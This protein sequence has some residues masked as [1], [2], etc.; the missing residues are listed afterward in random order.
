MLHVKILN[1]EDIAGGAGGGLTDAELRATPVDVAIVSGSS[2]GTEY[3]EGDTDASISGGAILWEDTSDTLRAVSAA[4]PLPVNVVAGGT[5]GTQY[6]EADTDASIT[7]TAIMW[8]DTSDTLRAVSASKP[9]PVSV[10]AAIPAGTNNIGDVDVLTLPALAAGTNNIGDV[11][12]LTVPAPLSTTGNGTAAAALRVTVASDST[13]VLAVTDNGGTLSI[14]DGAGS[15][16]VDAT[17]LSCNVAQMNGTAVTMGN[18]ASGT[19]VQR[20]TLANDSTGVLATVSTVTTVSTL[21]GG[22]VAH[23]GGDSGNPIKIGLKAKSSLSG[24]TLVSADD[25]TDAFADL[26]GAQITK[27]NAPNGDLKSEAVSNTDGASTAFSNF[28]A[29]ASTR[30]YI[31]AITAFRSDAGTSLAYVDFRDGTGGS[32]LWRM[33]L[34]PNGGSVI[35]SAV[36]LFKTSANTALAFDVSSAL[37]TVYINVS[38]FQSKA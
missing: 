8:E 27:L 5:S 38:G 2:S 22:G 1:P 17:N 19:G 36:P 9:L 21:T 14:D 35:T 3:T 13:G 20:V 24:V 23:D 4:K 18:G 6:T 28:G 12:V 16:T 30:N 25:R 33:P 11:D 34:P 32:V 10:I 7:G 29:V 26:D 31:T 15:I 37:S